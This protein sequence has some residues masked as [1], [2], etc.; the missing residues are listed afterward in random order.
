MDCRKLYFEPSFQQQIGSDPQEILLIKHT[1]RNN[2][3]VIKF[4]NV[5]YTYN[6]EYIPTIMRC[7]HSDI[8]VGKIATDHHPRVISLTLRVL[9][10]TKH[11]KLSDD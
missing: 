11:A 5:K 10:L 2:H 8:F 9:R 3:L 6:N 7:A 4:E 1:R